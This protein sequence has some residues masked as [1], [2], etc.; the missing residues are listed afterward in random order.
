MRNKIMKKAMAGVL[1]AAMMTGCLAGCSGNSESGT[2]GGNSEEKV[3]LK[4]PAW[5]TSTIVYFNKLKEGFE[6]EH[7]DINIELID[8]P[9]GDYTK[10]LSVMLNGGNELDI[11][12][13]KETDTTA[14]IAERGQLEDLTSYIEKD[15]I[16]LSVYNGAD[17]DFNI[18]GKQI[19]MPVS[20]GYQILFYNKD[21]FD[22]AGV[23]YPDNDM[24]WTE[25]EDLAGKLTSGEGNDKIY[26]GYIHT[27]Q[28]CVQNMGVQDGEHT[29]LDTDYSF[30]K[31]YYEMVLRMQEEGTIMD[32]S[33]LKTGNIHYSG[34]F[35]QGQVAMLPMGSWFISTILSKIEA[36]E[37]DVNWGIATLPHPDNTEAGYTAGSTTP[38]GISVNSEH[39]DE[40]WEFI[41]YC[42][43]EEGAS[44]YAE[45]GEMP[46]MLN[47]TILSQIASKERMPEG[48][49]EALQVKKIS[50]ERPMDEKSAEVNQMLG[51]EHSL[52]MIGELSVDEGLAEMAERSKEIQGK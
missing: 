10:K 39:K 43:G 15:N 40:A 24:T 22:A 19:A 8:I 35:L 36:G 20:T 26:G 16:D 3:T 9:S 33:T 7:P 45:C 48:T 21:I 11:V 23:D 1:V 17:A 38:M 28:S 2:G 25:F 44:V 5:D 29:I 37:S 51:E 13:I 30:F 47:D 6:K 4:V 41:K 46:A 18:D 32:Y 31:P 49:E 12:W 52:I 42:S 34:P 27:W 50:Q 14:S